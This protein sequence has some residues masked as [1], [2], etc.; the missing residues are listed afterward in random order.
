M[1]L[2]ISPSKE[3]RSR[4]EAASGA[5][6]SPCWTCSTCDQECPVNR[7]CG[8][9]RPQ[10]I[11]RLATLGL[12]DEM[13]SLPDL[14]YCLGCRRCTNVCPNQVKPESLIQHL[15]RE[16]VVRGRVSMDTYR[17][18]RTF[19]LRFQRIRRRLAQQLI[20]GETDA[21]DPQDWLRWL[22][23]PLPDEGGDEVVFIGPEAANGSWR[24]DIEKFD[25]SA[26]FTCSEC[27]NACPVAGDRT[28]FDPQWIFRMANLGQKEP[29][30]TSASLWLCIECGRC[31]ETCGQ[32]V[33]GR[34]VIEYLRQKAIARG[35]VSADF[36][37]RWSH[38]QS[39]I[40]PQFVGEIDALFSPAH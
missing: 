14:W 23:Q 5:G 4:I 37:F 6:L 32:L 34:Q 2:A 25:L 39:W 22:H 35:Y 29:L 15:R 36:P 38:A 17:R 10:K 11:V 27:S 33:Q 16:A 30:L 12:L 13:L 7:S 3:I 9:L 26:C 8:R 20:A 19:F 18:Y 21:P 24:A 28:V 31:T 1:S 40:Y